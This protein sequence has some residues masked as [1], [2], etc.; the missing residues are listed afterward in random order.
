MLIVNSVALMI[1]VC[2]YVIIAVA[3]VEAQ[4]PVAMVIPTLILFG[5]AK[6]VI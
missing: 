1:A 2:L 4:A 5:Y 3:S 6:E